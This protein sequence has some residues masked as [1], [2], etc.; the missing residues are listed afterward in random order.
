M[1]RKVSGE[2]KKHHTRRR[3]PRCWR[4][5]RLS[6][7]RWKQVELMVVVGWWWGWG[8]NKL[9]RFMV[10]Y[11]FKEWND[12]E[13]KKKNELRAKGDEIRK[14]QIKKKKKTR[15]RLTLCWKVAT[16]TCVYEWWGESWDGGQSMWPFTLIL[17]LV[18]PHVTITSMQ[19]GQLGCDVIYMYPPS[20]PI[21]TPS[22]DANRQQDGS[23]SI[24]RDALVRATLVKGWRLGGWHCCT[25]SQVSALCF[26]ILKTLGLC[27]CVSVC[28]YPYVCK[29][30]VYV[31]CIF[32]RPYFPLLVQKKQK[33]EVNG[34]VRW[35]QF[36]QEIWGS[37]DHPNKHALPQRMQ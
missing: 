23:D 1:E 6:A 4:E 8:E 34:A 31:Q 24:N 19:Q 27:V 5:I 35:W 7:G 36:Q 10:I 22:L 13:A 17:S 30:V 29:C 32:R 11:N 20:T 2:K 33:G 3:N 14:Q 16:H 28:V 26:L 9:K 21:Q 18:T 37:P 15:H 25:V 12:L